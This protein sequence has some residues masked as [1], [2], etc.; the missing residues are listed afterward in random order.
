MTTVSSTLKMFDA[1]TG[2]LKNITNG[3]NMMISTMHKMQDVTNRNTNI[4]KSLIAAKQQIASAEAE[5][6]RQIQNATNSQNKFNQSV[7]NGT[8]SSSGLKRSIAGVAAAY[9]SLQSLKSVMNLSDTYSNTTARLNL[10]NDGQQTTAEL[11]DKIMD[12]A[13]RARASYQLTA[14]VVAKLG[15]RAG[16]AFKSND[17]TIQ[18]AEN[19]NKQF[20][21]A[22]ASQAEMASASLQ[23]TQALGS[24][25]LRGEELN[26]VFEAA[27]NV[28]QTIADYMKVPIGAIREMASDGQITAD[29]VKNAMLSA[30]DEINKDFESMPMT[31]AQVWS[32][33]QNILIDA[34][35]PLLQVIGQGAQFIYDNWSKIEPILVGV[36]A[37]A[38]T[39]AV[40][41]G[42]QAAATWIATGAAA[43]F[44]ATL[45]AN[46]LTW[47]VLLI[48]V[49]VMAIYKWVQSVGGLKIAWMIVC[50]ALLT[51]WDWVKIGFMTG[52]YWVIELFNKLQVSFKTVSTN[53]QNFMGDMKAGFLTI[54]Q[55]MVN[56]G[57]DIING[58]INTLNKIP[59]VSIDLIDQM[60]FGTNAQLENEAA[61]QARNNELAQYKN[62]IDQQIAERDA[63]LET[64]KSEAKLATAA[65]SAEISAAQAAKAASDA[66]KKNDSFLKVPNVPAGGTID[67]VNKVGKIEDKVDISSED[68][69]TMREL[70]EMKSIQ[71]FV[72][73]TPT[74][75]VNGDMHVRNESDIDLIVSKLEERLT[76]EINSG[77]SGVHE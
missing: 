55:N 30:T 70:A 20:V 71:N 76:E 47:I 72:T 42:I 44:F 35:G 1:M 3:M 8:T 25:V 6:N 18:F 61:K 64:M 53:I 50:N 67:K 49:V 12:S 23:L 68:L 52:V 58:F 43:T 4:D 16:D 9:L 54:L 21:I 33:I 10:M 77:A 39:L 26:A 14:D 56:G 74:V 5:I 34:F 40:G 62:K 48:G 7:N 38:V 13:N 32:L 57:I 19:L 15:Q 75:S 11:Q 28:I 37:G 24:G 45:L 60:T 65:R 36:A 31:F 59:G 22:G 73:L 27:P 69:K 41:L 51:T 29:I 17:E 63:A 2:P 46:P 66:A